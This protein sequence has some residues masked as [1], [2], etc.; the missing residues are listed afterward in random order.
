MTQHHVSAHVSP[1]TCPRPR[2]C[3]FATHRSNLCCNILHGLQH[4]SEIS[5][6]FRDMGFRNSGQHKEYQ[7]SLWDLKHA[8]ATVFGRSRSDG[9]RYRKSVPTRRP[10]IPSCV[11]AIEIPTREP[12]VI[13][14]YPRKRGRNARFRH[15]GG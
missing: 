7:F 11:P 6:R 2:L 10:P 13:D 14:W 15:N 4:S 9:E 1:P 5:N 8:H 12:C 3:A